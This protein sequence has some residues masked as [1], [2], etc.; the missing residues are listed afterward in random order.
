[1]PSPIVVWP[2]IT[3][4]A[5][6]LQ[7]RPMRTCGPITANAPTVVPAPT[8]AVGAT[9]GERIDSRDRRHREQQLGLDHRLAV[10]F[11][12]RSG[13]HE[14]AAHGAESHDQLELIAGDDVLAELGA[15]NAAQLH[16]TAHRCC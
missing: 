2:S 11:G 5:P 10:D 3:A 1:M 4:D 8:T 13:F 7:L 16:A 14:R 12:G 15:V 9:R 6:I